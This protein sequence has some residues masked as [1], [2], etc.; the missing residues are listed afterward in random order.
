[1][2]GKKQ[3]LFA[4]LFL[5]S[6]LSLLPARVWAQGGSGDEGEGGDRGGD[7]QG[8]QQPQE[9]EPQQ[10]QQRPERPIYLIGKVMLDDGQEP[11]HPVQVELVCQG[12]VVR[13]E[14]TSGSG[15]FSM[16]VGGSQAN[17]G[18]ADASL[19]SSDYRRYGGFGGGGGGFSSGRLN[20]GGCE[21][22]AR[23]P[24]YQ[25]DVIAVRGQN[26]DVGVIILH[27]MNAP[28]G[29]TV[30]LKTL[31]APEDTRK[32]LEKAGRELQKEK[33]NSSKAA[34]ELEKAVE[35]YPEFALAWQML[36]EVRLAQ[37]DQ[38]AAAE[39]FEQA[40][41]AD[42]G[43]VAPYLSQAMMAMEE[44]Q[45]MKAAQLS[46]QALELSPQLIKAHYF[47]ALAN[48]PLGRINIAEE[49][50]LLVLDSNQVQAYPLIYY[51]LGSVEAEREN[52]PSAAARYRTFLEV[53][54]NASL[55]SKLREQLDQWQKQG[56]IQ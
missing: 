7:D 25:S 49:S 11:G 27:S 23:M 32:A 4:V 40:R 10:P 45:W 13:R 34:K 31:A 55:A 2:I 14:Y 29:G 18:I 17:A 50:A 56:L 6:V 22:Q 52:F 35:I 46:G 44:E 8:Q 20:L 16:I 9:Q 47:N 24:G 41:A 37:N 54:P 5:L 28:D 42:P 43:Y 51:V 38:P 21:L 48:I 36:G 53:R 30:S 39:A 33:P 12:S 3:V 15:T 1:M 19:S 26:P